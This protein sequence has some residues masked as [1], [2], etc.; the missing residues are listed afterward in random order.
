MRRAQFCIPLALATLGT[1]H[2]VMAAPHHPGVRPDGQAAFAAT[3][4]QAIQAGLDRPALRAS[5]LPA[6]VLVLLVDF[7]DAAAGNAGSSQVEEDFFGGPGSMRDYYAR[8]SHGRYDL[9][10]TVHGWLRAPRTLAFY[11]D[12]QRGIGGTPPHSART[13]VEE[14]VRVAAGG[15]DFSR[16]DNDGPDGLPASGDDD[17]MVDALVVVHAGDAA[18]TTGRASDLISHAW[19]TTQ[20][21]S[22]ADGVFVWSYALVAVGSPLGVRGHEFGH[23][24][25]IAVLYSRRA[26][27]RDAP[28]GLGDWSLMGSGSWLGDGNEPADLDGPSKIELGFVDPIVPRGNGQGLELAAVVS[29]VAPQIYKVWTHGLPEREY[30]VLENRRPQPGELDARLPAGGMLVYHVDLRRAN[31]DD[32]DKPRVRLLQA[33]GREDLEGFHNAGDA[34]DPYPGTGNQCCRIGAD[35]RPSTLASDGSDTQI[36]IDSISVPTFT[37]RFDLQVET[38]ALLRVVAQTVRELDGDND[39]NP[40]AGEALELGVEIEN[41][42]LPTTALALQWRAE[43]AASAVWSADRAQLPAL[44]KGGRGT[45]RFVLRPDAALSDPAGLGLVG[46]AIESGGAVHEL[47]H[48]LALGS[49]RGFQAC[50]YAVPSR[51]SA[52]CSDPAAD[53]QVVPLAAAGSWNLE[54]SPGDLSQVYRSASGPRYANQSDVALQSPPFN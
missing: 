42:G 39:G 3:L 8:A 46:M 11:A 48:T 54:T 7:A 50:L 40:E 17:G 23:L 20:T 38:R 1:A 2:V 37:M 24:R 34:G 4:E 19:T 35:T 25:G 6:R 41:L 53:W 51:V 5:R 12:N 30:F 15:L 9:G 36:L 49:T 32:P 16:F 31:N 28:G 43:P 22:T 26:A 18:E 21:V 13:L 44:D 52:D 45:V 47:P 33:D 29:A 10:G 27:S 14:S